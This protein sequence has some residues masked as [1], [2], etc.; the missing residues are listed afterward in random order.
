MD[1]QTT[2]VDSPRG[3]FACI[4]RKHHSAIGASMVRLPYIHFMNSS[5]S[6]PSRPSPWSLIALLRV[7][8]L[9]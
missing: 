8:V 3:L 9:W 6:T 2:Y 4:R 7:L 1:Q 5:A